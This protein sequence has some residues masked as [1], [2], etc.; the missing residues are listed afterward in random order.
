[1]K[2]QNKITLTILFIAVIFLVFSFDQK[3]QNSRNQ[4]VKGSQ[5]SI[6]QSEK[7]KIPEAETTTKS[8]LP[9]DLESLIFSNPQNLSINHINYQNGLTG[10]RVS[11]NLDFPLYSA[12]NAYSKMYF[13][14]RHWKKINAL[15]SPDTEKMGFIEMENKNYQVQVELHRLDTDNTGILI[16]II[17]PQL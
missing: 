9:K 8:A 4:Q 10:Y 15:F 12:F 1:M 16:K 7:I 13:D 5:Y 11:M 14:E 2:I 6:L 3:S 17:Q